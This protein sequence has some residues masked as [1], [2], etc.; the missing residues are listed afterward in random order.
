MSDST[1]LAPTSTGIMYGPVH[2][3]RQKLALIGSTIAPDLTVNELALF[4]EVCMR[5]QLDPFSGQIHA[6]KRWSNQKQSDGS[7]KKVGRVTFQTS[8]EGFLSL[9]ERTNEYDGMDPPEYGPLCTCGEVVAK[10]EWD[11]DAGERGAQ[12][13]VAHPEWATV[14]VYRRGFTRPVSAMA[15]WHEY[16]PGPKQGG[17]WH[18]M[19]RVMLAKV[20]RVAAL[21]LAFPYVMGGLYSDDEMQQSDREPV[22][23]AVAGPAGPAPSPVQVHNGPAPGGIATPAPQGAQATRAQDAS[24]P[25]AAPVG[26]VGPVHVGTQQQGSG[27]PGDTAAPPAPSTGA[28]DRSARSVGPTAKRKNVVPANQTIPAPS[29]EVPPAP[30]SAGADEQAVGAA[31]SGEGAPSTPATSPAPQPDPATTP[32]PPQTAPELHPVSFTD[33][34]PAPAQADDGHAV[35]LDQMREEAR[36]GAGVLHL[37]RTKLKNQKFAL[38]NQP[39]L[40]EPPVTPTA[41]SDESL[42]LF[43]DQ[44]Y[45]SRTLADLREG[46][47][48]NV[49]G[50]IQGLIDKIHETGVKE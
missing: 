18:K 2:L 24:A 4:G 30:I 6:I 16:Y 48:E 38:A 40:P 46:E 31:V 33:E 32:P 25:P 19:P 10:G 50:V 41:D 36:K 17:M 34:T 44:N 9:A 1:A 13:V 20:A 21:R 12:R 45:P 43:I 23:E 26:D 22:S 47:L 8:Q 15:Y 28:P 49:L 29:V 14:T 42:R 11:E 27:S 3:D 35:Y 37:L 39:L 7:W 5:K